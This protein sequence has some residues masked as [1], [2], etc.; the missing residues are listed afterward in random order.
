MD[1]GRPAHLPFRPRVLFF[2]LAAMLSAGV[3]SGACRQLSKRTSEKPRAGQSRMSGP[4][5]IFHITP[6]LFGVWKLPMQTYETG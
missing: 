2:Q 3:I 4:I 1:E 6:S 5:L